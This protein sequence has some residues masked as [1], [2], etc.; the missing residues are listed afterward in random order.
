MLSKEKGLPEKHHDKIY[1][2]KQEYTFKEAEKIKEN[3]SLRG[4]LHVIKDRGINIA[5]ASNAITKTT[6]IYL[7]KL[8]IIHLIDFI[9]SNQMVTACKPNPEMYL[10]T[11]IHFSVCPKQTIIVEDSAVGVKAAISSCANVF[12]VKNLSET[13]NVVE[14]LHKLNNMKEEKTAW[15]SENLTVLIPMAGK[16]SRF[17]KANYSFPKPLIDIDGKTMIHKV[18]ENINIKAKYVFVVLKEHIEQYN[19]DILLKSIVND[20]EIVVQEGYVEGA[21]SSTL[22]AEKF[23]NNNNQLIIAN[24]DQLV[25]YDSVDF[26]YEMISKQA[27]GGLL[28][29]NASHPKWSYAKHNEHGI[30]SEVAEKKVISNSATVGIYYWGKGS[31][32]VKYAKQMIQKNI[33]T[34]NE[35]YVAPV[36][37]EAISDGKKILIYNVKEMIGLGTPEDLEKY[38]KSK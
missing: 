14:Y 26:M 12:T 11:M 27:D 28:T 13:Y 35:F 23:L 25:D 32:Y 29:F 5:V 18:I 20:C 31:D 2:S 7:K 10:K 9:V 34:N 3:K 22:L 4:L 8:G 38:L 30:V 21:V 16:G 6:K 19:I 15:N 33:R 24:S 37:N 1:F 17:V 36:Y